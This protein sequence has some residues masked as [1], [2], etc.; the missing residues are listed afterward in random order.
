VFFTSHQLGDAERLADRFAVLVEGRLVAC[1]DAPQLKDRLAERGVMRLR[2]AE[3]PGALLDSVR[4]LAPRATWS[5]E[6]LIVPG[7][8]AL[9]PR[10]LD[11]VRERG[12]EIRGLTAEEG[13]LD[14]LYRELVAEA[15]A[16][17]SAGLPGPGPVQGGAE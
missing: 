7:P 11:R 9:R 2:L 10:V 16:H 15:G 13:R 8:A 14:V 6:E 1:L 3:R 17:G 5:G 4:E 12:V